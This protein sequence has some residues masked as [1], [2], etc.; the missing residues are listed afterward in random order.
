MGEGSLRALAASAT[1][2]VEEAVP[3]TALDATVTRALDNQR[4][5]ILVH[6][7]TPGRG[8]WNC[9]IACVLT[10][11][12]DVEALRGAWNDLGERHDALRIRFPWRGLEYP[13]AA[14]GAVSETTVPFRVV[15]L[16][17]RGVEASEARV[18]LQVEELEGQFEL[19]RAPLFRV[20]V[21]RLADDVHE[22]VW[23]YFSGMFDGWSSA[24]VL[25]EL[26]AAY[27][28]RVAG[29][30]LALPPAPSFFAHLLRH[31]AR[32]WQ[33]AATNLTRELAGYQLPTSLAGPPGGTEEERDVG[34]LE[35]EARAL[36]VAMGERPFLVDRAAHRAVGFPAERL[37][38]LEQIARSASVG[39]ASLLLSAW[40]VVLMREIE[41]APTC[42]S[43]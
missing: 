29:R 39:V 1:R 24:I 28:A 6:L 25:R 4:F 17:G 23:T 7:A 8:A 32:D 21:A 3:S 36:F 9:Q 35:P 11:R 15:D 20:A 10:G 40:G 16:P 41:G 13:H 33:R 19:E 2:V 12:L 18:E 43:A 42:S 31:N 14:I 34:R 27:D 37:R 30:A 5:P 38:R 26:L 22:L